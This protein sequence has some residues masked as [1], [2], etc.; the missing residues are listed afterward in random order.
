MKL[1]FLI[2]KVL[3]IR[4]FLLA[5]PMMFITIETGDCNEDRY[6]SIHLASF[7]E[8]QNANSFVNAMTKKGKLIFWKKADVQGKGEYYRVYLGKYK[9]RD[10]AVEFWKILKEEGAVSYFG[11]HEFREE[12]IS[13]PIEKL[14][15]VTEMEETD[16]LQASIPG[17][18]EGRFVDNGDGTVTDRKTNLMWIKNGWRIDFFSA[19][20][21]GDA[22]KKCEG[23]RH[24]GYIDWRLPTIKE[25]KSL[26]DKNNEYPAMVEPN[27]FENIIMHMPYWSR[28]EFNS[29]PSGSLETTNRAYTVMLY[30]GRISHQGINKFAFIMPVR[31]LN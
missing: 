4:I 8:L 24:G 29:S 6:Y 9:N 10:E 25:W 21:W 5:L 30:Y 23:F 22:I 28:T 12:P 7:K 13:E 15:D 1:S 17:V 18:E 27:P 14:P 19:V 11:V 31:S 3:L 26:L 2:S 20:N 16:M